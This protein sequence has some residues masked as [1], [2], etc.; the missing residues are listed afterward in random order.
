MFASP[1]AASEWWHGTS[2]FFSQHRETAG[3][4]ALIA[5]VAIVAWV[6]G[7]LAI[8][9]IARGVRAGSA[10]RDRRAKRLIRRSSRPPSERPSEDRLAE[11]RGAVRAQTASAVLRGVLTFTVVALASLMTLSEVGLDV[12]PLIATAGIVGV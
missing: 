1:P 11:Q 5:A 7:R 12:G 10:G 8:A 9:T 6:L 4:I 3:K 2:S